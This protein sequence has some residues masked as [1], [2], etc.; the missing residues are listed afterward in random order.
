M[1]TNRTNRTNLKQSQHPFVTCKE[2]S[3]RCLV[4]CKEREKRYI[5]VPRPSTHTFGVPQRSHL[6]SG[7]LVAMARIRRNTGLLYTSGYR[8]L[9][10]GPACECMCLIAR[11]Y[12]ARL[13]TFILLHLSLRASVAR[14]RLTKGRIPGRQAQDLPPHVLSS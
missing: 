14:G 8:F 13:V 2:A 4:H 9:L 6:S 5:R 1:P 3:H 11:L 12:M 7:T 10:G